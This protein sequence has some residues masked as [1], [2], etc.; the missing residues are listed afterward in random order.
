[1]NSSQA[2]EMDVFNRNRV[3]SAQQNDIECLCLRLFALQVSIH[4]LTGAGS[5]PIST[6]VAFASDDNDAAT[7][8][9]NT[10]KARPALSVAQMAAA[11]GAAAASSSLPRPTAANASPAKKVR[12]LPSNMASESPIKTVSIRSS[13]AALAFRPFLTRPPAPGVPSPLLV[14]V[15]PHLPVSLDD[16]L[17]PHSYVSLTHTACHC[18]RLP[19]PGGEQRRGR[20]RYHETGESFAF[21]RLHKA[22]RAAGCAL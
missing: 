5:A 10:Q 14:P 21:V 8:A 11:A 1:M 12:R 7:T 16:F 13:L 2:V 19:P 17:V 15:A 18:L 22:P 4:Q 3:I 20:G 6:S 9:H